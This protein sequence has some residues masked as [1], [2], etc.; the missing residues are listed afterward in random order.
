VTFKTK[1]ELAMDMMERAVAAQIPRGVL[2]ADAFYGRAGPLRVKARSLGLEY[3]VAIDADTVVRPLSRTGRS[4]SAQRV[5]VVAKNKRYRSFTW[6]QGSKAPLAARFAFEQVRLP[7]GDDVT[8]VCEWEAGEALP[9][10]CAERA[11]ADLTNVARKA[12]A[13]VNGP[14]KARRSSLRS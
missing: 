12:N 8:L 10:T 2:L 1:T 6:R 7:E 5:D 13:R 11:A 4:K 3:I 9:S 14:R